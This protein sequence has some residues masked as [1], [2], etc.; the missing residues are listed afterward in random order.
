MD[1]QMNRGAFFSVRDSQQIDKYKGL[2]T[3][4]LYLSDVDRIG[5]VAGDAQL[6]THSKF[7]LLIP[8]NHSGHIKTAMVRLKFVGMPITPNGAASFGFGYL[9]SNFVKN[10]YSS[11]IGFNNQL[12]CAFGVDEVC[13]VDDTRVP[14]LETTFHRLV[15]GQ[16]TLEGIAAT[17]HGAVF[18]S[19]NDTTSSVSSAVMYPLA[20]ITQAAYDSPSK[21]TIVANIG[22]PLSDNWILCDNPFGKTLSFDLVG[23]DMITL[24]P[25]GNAGDEA[26]IICLE[27]KLLPDNQSNDKFSY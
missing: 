14:A 9:K 23:E 27:V 13:V 24:L 10:C 4:Q 12:L 19:S 18:D 22:K 15:N 2:N 25:L 7:N 16:T 1:T 17:N 20:K 21:T 5:Y 3:Y 8:D 11:K 6:G 26:T